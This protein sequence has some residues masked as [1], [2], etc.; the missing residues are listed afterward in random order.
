MRDIVV[1]NGV[2]VLGTYNDGDIQT[3]VVLCFNSGMIVFNNFN[4]GNAGRWVEEIPMVGKDIS[5]GKFGK[6]RWYKDYK[7][8]LASGKITKEYCAMI[9]RINGVT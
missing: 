4:R 6:E 3:M 1:Q 8:L 7:R 9:D 2:C 5:S